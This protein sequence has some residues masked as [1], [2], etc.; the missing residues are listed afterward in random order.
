MRKN[1]VL[2]S[3]IRKKSPV[4]KISFS[5][6]KFLRYCPSSS[7][8]SKKNKERK[9]TSSFFF[10]QKNISTFRV[11]EVLKKKKKSKF[12]NFNIWKFS[13]LTIQQ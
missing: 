3:G 9:K 6:I 2:C 8:Y 1:V 13:M 7:P 12:C 11:A 5:I 10:F 4:N